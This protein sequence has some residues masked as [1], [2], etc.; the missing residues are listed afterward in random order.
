MT[1]IS[2]A[3]ANTMSGMVDFGGDTHAA[4]IALAAAT[5]GIRPGLLSPGSLAFPPPRATRLS[6]ASPEPR[7]L[8][9]ADSRA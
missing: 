6:P 2:T 7:S 9:T 1:L 5:V 4:L 3:V 8:C